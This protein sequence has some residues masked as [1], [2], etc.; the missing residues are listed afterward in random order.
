MNLKSSI[1]PLVCVLPFVFLV[2]SSCASTKVW[3][4]ESNQN[5]GKIGYQTGSESDAKSILKQKFEN[6][7][8]SI[9]PTGFTK[10]RDVLR[11]ETRSFAYMDTATDVSRYDEDSNASA[12]GSGRYAQ[13]SSR[14]G[15]TITTTR[16]VP[17]T[18]RYAEHWREAEIACDDRASTNTL[19]SHAPA[20]EC[21]IGQPCLN[22][23]DCASL[24]R[25]KISASASTEF[26]RQ[27][28]ECVSKWGESYTCPH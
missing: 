26:R 19:R 6:A 13:G 1:T 15:G 11:R 28:G 16:Q 4:I 14:T 2:I 7:A 27:H 25:C 20:L 17:V 3:T 24:E 22:D 23:D 18:S 9:C 21:K 8:S 5:G 12:F 10:I